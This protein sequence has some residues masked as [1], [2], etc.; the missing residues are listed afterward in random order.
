MKV[1]RLSLPGVQ[2]LTLERHADARGSFTVT[3]HA[4]ALA[5]AGIFTRFVQDNE[6]VSTRG[7]LRGMHLQRPTAQGK[8]VRC[9]AGEICDVVVDLRPD[10]ATFGRWLGVM[11]SEARP[12]AIWVPA[13][14]AHGFL[15]LSERSVVTYKV[16]AP[17]LPAEER[18]LAWDDPEVDIAWPLR[19]LFPVLSE[20]DRAGEPLSAFRD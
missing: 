20:R 3:W 15:T 1:E 5:A 11:L 12:E 10:S 16:D 19:G 7:V 14:F 18:V 13:G 17:Y 9:A 8:L 6:T 2:R 4:D